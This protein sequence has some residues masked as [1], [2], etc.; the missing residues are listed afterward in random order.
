[1][2]EDEIYIEFFNEKFQKLSK[3]NYSL[4][5]DVSM[6]THPAPHN[7]LDSGWL[8]LVI[9]D[10]TS[11]R[12]AVAAK[13]KVTCEKMDLEKALSRGSLSSQEESCI[14]GCNRKNRPKNPK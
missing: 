2:V 9:G 8:S 1:M 3:E 13:L 10:S 12:P 4:R 14:G 11:T 6:A 7:L 5:P